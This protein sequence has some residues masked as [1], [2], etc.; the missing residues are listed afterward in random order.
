MLAHESN[1]AK[2]EV[3]MGD[4]SCGCGCNPE[5]VVAAMAADDVV[6]ED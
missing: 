6:V 3:R 2:V 1:L 5:N 4:G